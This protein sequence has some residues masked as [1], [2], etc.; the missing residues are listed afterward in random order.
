[1]ILYSLRLSGFFN[2]YFCSSSTLYAICSQ[3][4]ITTLGVIIDEALSNLIVSFI[5]D[6][7]LLQHIQV[8]MGPVQEAT[9][10][11][12]GP[13][14]HIRTLMP[15]CPSMRREHLAILGFPTGGCY[16]LTS[17]STAVL[18][19]VA[20]LVVLRLHVLLR[21]CSTNNTYDTRR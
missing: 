19:M 16:M 18:M 10:H 13:Y 11:H 17:E 2:F 20:C 9:G 7:R 15:S 14:P 4:T 8:V 6:V 1:M 5:I 3:V 12:P 21:C